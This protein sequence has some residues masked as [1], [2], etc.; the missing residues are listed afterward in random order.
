MNKRYLIGKKDGFDNNKNAIF[1][2]IVNIVEI[3]KDE[4]EVYIGYDAIN[5][6][7]EQELL[8]I[9][10]SKVTDIKKEVEELSGAIIA[11]EFKPGQYDKRADAVEQSLNLFYENDTK[12]ITSVI[13]EI[14]K[15]ITEK[16]KQNIYHAIMNPIECRKKNLD[17]LKEDTHPISLE[18]PIIKTFNK[19]NESEL[20]EYF[21]D[22]Q[23][24]F[25]FEDLKFIQ[26][27]FREKNRNPNLLEI[28][29]L[30]TYWSDHCRHTTFLT[31]LLKVEFSN[32]KE[33]QIVKKAWEKYIQQRQK[34]NRKTPTTLM[35]IA[36][37]GTRILKSQ[38]K[39]KDLEIS[40]E[41]NANSFKVMVDEEKEEKEYLLMFKNE[42]HNHPTE[43]EPFG[44]AS[45]CLGGAIR[46]TLSGRA[47]TFQGM[48]ITGSGNPLKTKVLPNKLHQ[49][50]IT[51][52]AAE[53][54]SSY[55]NQIGMATTNVKE[56]YDE[57]FLAK[58]METGFVVGAVKASEIKREEALPGDIVM[59]I[60]GG[61]GRD[62][63]GGATGSSKKQTED[64]KEVASAE[65]QKGNAIVE[66]KI[67]KL[68]KN[69]KFTNLIKKSNDFGAG[70]ICVAL[71]ELAD[72]IEINLDKVKLKYKGLS[73]MEIALSESQERMAYVINK[74]D[75]E[76]F[77]KL[78]EEANLEVVQVATITNN[79]K[80][81][82]KYKEEIVFDLDAHFIASNGISKK[83]NVK[84][85]ENWNIKEF[86]N[87]EYTKSQFLKTLSSLE[88]ASQRGLQEMFDSSIGRGTVI[89][90][91][92]GK[93]QTTPSQVSAQKIPTKGFTN[94]VSVATHGYS[95]ELANI[96]PYLAAQYSVVTS[97]AKL[98][99][100][101]TPIKNAKA[102]YQEYFEKMKNAKTWSK[103]LQS[104]LGTLE[105][106]ILFEVP[107]IG[108][109]DSMSGTYK[110]LTVPPT[111]I[112]F[113][114]NVTKTNKIITTE[115]KQ[116]NSNIYLVDLPKKD[117]M[118]IDLLKTKEI[119]KMIESM[120][121][122]NKILSSFVIEE[123]GW[124]TALTKMS[125]GNRI[126]FE[127]KDKLLL[128]EAF[129]FKKGSIIIETQHELQ[130]D[131]FQLLGKTTD[132]I[133]INEDKFLIKELT[134]LNEGVLESIFPLKTKTQGK[135][136]KKIFETK[137]EFKYKHIIETPEVL[138]PVFPGSNC[139]DDL[140]KAFEYEGASCKQLI[141]NNL[142]NKKLRESQE[143]FIK[144]L[145]KTHILCIPGGF[146]AT[147]EPD[148]SGKF[149]SIF[150][151]SPKV[152]KA[153]EEHLKEK[154]LIIGIC[155][156]FQ[157]L[158]KTGLVPY[159]KFIEFKGDEPILY[160]NLINKHVSK[161]VTTKVISN[162]SPWVKNTEIGKTHVLAM[163][164][165]EGRIIIQENMAKELF[166]NGQIP[167][168]YVDL[169]N[170]VTL[171]S[172]Y[173]PNS[174]MFA[175]EA[176]TSIDGL[177]L[178]KMSHSERFEEGNFKNIYGNKAQKIIKNGVEYFKGV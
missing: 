93:F 32:S 113:A 106:Q 111:L 141:I 94:T 54:F 27:Y 60:G 167:F 75:K 50:F 69:Y 29:M 31:E 158:I 19:F 33:S 83:T 15:E 49:A 46:D 42:T 79:K 78:C 2:K 35:D 104:L 81:I 37:H 151:K 10:F 17:V 71:V 131:V 116:K 63:I 163:S 20:K 90:P 25:E 12:I 13:I 95:P 51:R 110:N 121:D 76:E 21:K 100:S 80:V 115:L 6:M 150:L 134:D 143:S 55:G 74:K 162:N 98:V 28:K 52:T 135:L 123:G 140:Q 148:G 152:Q 149:I 77:E 67:Q 142:T 146:S 130:G 165:G 30:D 147:D 128:K 125:F 102:S 153:I 169:K 120:N 11:Y 161:F 22:N 34:I 87:K 68:T 109:K 174:S 43:I 88:V 99:S 53:G 119:F 137:K 124:L 72:S 170:N 105:S 129:S 136:I 92:G 7:K 47:Y 23:F 26:E 85:D 8:E 56:Y 59:M 138:I 61:T 118:Q 82:M 44:G 36:T 114:I 139:E 166:K 160:K 73:P 107:S 178:G 3:T 172:E 4:L 132:E 168:Q 112:A 108:G 173:N 164:H 18:I 103:P 84:V 40:N 175:I 155:N 96:S 86:L 64:I 9:I 156:G 117:M 101:G 122:E 58:R 65:V 159:G 171:D 5:L 91:Y 38:D 70:G 157:A 144:Q 57:G 127:I 177:V 16:Q 145:K 89:S 1:E 48:R 176:M 24:S 154:R 66:R 133:K 45:T 39:L 41:I 62:G 97:I 14:K 126:G